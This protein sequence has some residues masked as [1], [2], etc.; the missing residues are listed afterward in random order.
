MSKEKYSWPLQVDPFDLVDKLK[1]SSF[2]LSGARLTQ[3][4]LVKQYEEKWASKIGGRAVMCSSG[5]TANILIAMWWKEQL[6]KSGEWEDRREILLPVVTWP[7]SVNNWLMLNFKPIFFDIS[8]GNWGMDYESVAQ[9][10]H[11]NKDKVAGI[12]PTSLLGMTPDLRLIELAKIAGVKIALDNCEASFNT[13]DRRYYNKDA[14]GINEVVNYPQYVS[15]LCTST[16]STYI[17]HYTSSIEGGVIHCQSE[18][19][20]RFHLLARNHGLMRSLVPYSRNKITKRGVLG[21]SI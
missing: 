19:E 11:K 20:Y 18:E 16:T 8:P 6:I 21:I 9:Y 3:G 14:Y 7:T 17:G 12:F 5:S 2:I 10:L 15:S 1:V 4:D 13:I